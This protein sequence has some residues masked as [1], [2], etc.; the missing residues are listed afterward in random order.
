MQ[1]TFDEKDQ[2]GPNRLPEAKMGPLVSVY[3]FKTPPLFILSMLMQRL[4][5]NSAL[6]SISDQA[7]YD[8]PLS[9]KLFFSLPFIVNNEK[10]IC[11]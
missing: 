3:V 9:L 7:L 10:L 1:S 11:L 5:W 6:R 8:I 2:G 4:N